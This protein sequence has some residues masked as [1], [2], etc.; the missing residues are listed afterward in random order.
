M[1]VDQSQGRR[2][3]DASTEE[4]QGSCL[5]GNRD[6]QSHGSMPTR[7][8]L[9]RAPGVAGSSREPYDLMSLKIGSD[10]NLVDSNIYVRDNKEM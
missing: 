4:L 10:K 3:T 1:A 2:R 9:F 6:E 5:G 7:P 8:Q